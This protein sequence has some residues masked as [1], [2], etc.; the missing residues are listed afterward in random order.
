[1]KTISKPVQ[2]SIITVNFNNA[3]GLRKTLNSVKPY[4]NINYEIIIIDNL[5]TDNSIDIS[6]SFSNYHK[7]MKIIS[8]KDNGIY[9]GMNKGINASKGEWI[10]FMNSGDSFYNFLD[11]DLL[12]SNDDVSVAYG[13]FISS[14]DIVK[15]YKIDY[16]KK[17]I[18]HACHQSMFFNYKILKE[19]LL[20]NTNYKIYSDYD[21]VNRIFL[22]K[23]KFKYFDV[24]ISKIEPNGIS[25]RISWQK[26]FDKILI[27]FKSYGFKGLI[28]SY[29]R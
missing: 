24:T 6:K 2:L 26:R 9:D 25:Q 8:E 28:N 3:L 4:S 1:M 17:G 23:Y 15:P 27:I 12:L 14:Q 5:S 21:L 29:I 7:D 22:L 18:I 10:I 13:N 19:N 20:Y 16:L 11:I